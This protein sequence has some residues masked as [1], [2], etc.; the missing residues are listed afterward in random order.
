V[1]LLFVSGRSWHVRDGLSA[2]D[3]G[4]SGMGPAF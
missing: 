1:Q 4:E 3:R 2:F